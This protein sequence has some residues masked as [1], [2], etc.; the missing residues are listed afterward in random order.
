MMATNINVER[1]LRTMGTT[2][3]C[4]PV[5]RKNVK[6]NNP[7]DCVELQQKETKIKSLSEIKNGIICFIFGV[8]LY[9]S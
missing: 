8:P 5:P 4:F 3:S 9:V 7:I 1:V 2:M 6:D